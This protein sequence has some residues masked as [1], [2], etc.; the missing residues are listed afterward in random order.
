MEKNHAKK[1]IEA[2]FLLFFAFFAFRAIKPAIVD[3]IIDKEGY[4][5]LRTQPSV[6]KL[7]VCKLTSWLP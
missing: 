4:A 2:I 1:H 7:F 3:S 5:L 6:D